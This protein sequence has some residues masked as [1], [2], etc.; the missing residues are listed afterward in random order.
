[1]LTIPITNYQIIT[2]QKNSDRV[3]LPLLATAVAQRPKAASGSRSWIPQPLESDGLPSVQSYFCTY[4]SKTKTIRTRGRRSGPAFSKEGACDCVGVVV[5]VPQTRTNDALPHLYLSW[6]ILPKSTDQGTVLV[7]SP[8]ARSGHWW[9]QC[10]GLEDTP[11]MK[12]L[13]FCVLCIV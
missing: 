3:L 9:F 1:M 8:S 5:V 7:K 12:S 10:T 11:C 13:N 4:K 2:F 6:R